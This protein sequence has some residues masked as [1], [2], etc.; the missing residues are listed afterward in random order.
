[1]R[2]L[3]DAGV[4]CAVHVQGFLCIMSSSIHHQLSGARPS[5]HV[6]RRSGKA[7]FQEPRIRSTLRI[8]NPPQPSVPKLTQL[9]PRLGSAHGILGG[10]GG[11]GWPSG[12]T[13]SWAWPRLVRGLV[14]DSIAQVTFGFVALHRRQRLDGGVRERERVSARSVA[15]V[16]DCVST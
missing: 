14:R 15:C 6:G 12:V 4:T 3:V 2:A 8:A 13:G 9:S 1:V 7:V 11:G 5:S 10:G 16:C